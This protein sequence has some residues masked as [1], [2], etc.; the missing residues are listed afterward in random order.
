V[1]LGA[2]EWRSGREWGGGGGCTLKRLR[3]RLRGQG[4]AIM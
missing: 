2:A 1:E 3:V 4:S